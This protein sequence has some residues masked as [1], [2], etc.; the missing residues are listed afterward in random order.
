LVFHIKRKEHKLKALENRA[1]W[2]IF[3]PK[4]DGEI[5]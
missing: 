5:A 3:G 4:R 2:N 1:I